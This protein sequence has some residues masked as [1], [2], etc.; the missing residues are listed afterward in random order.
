MKLSNNSKEQGV[1][2]TEGNEK[3]NCEQRQH[4][5]YVKF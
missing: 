3:L 1:R 2:E 5:L 4:K